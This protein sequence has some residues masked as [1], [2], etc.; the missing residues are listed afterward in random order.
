[1]TNRTRKKA[2]WIGSESTFGTAPSGSSFLYVPAVQIGEL[3]DTLQ[4][5][6]TDYFTNRSFG[7]APVVGPDGWS[8]D[9]DVPVC[10][11]ELGKAGGQSPS[12]D[13][14]LDLIC[15]SIFGTQY[16][17]DGLAVAST[18]SSTIT[19]D[20]G[21]HTQQDLLPTYDAGITVDGGNR[22]QWAFATS[23]S[24]ITPNWVTN[25]SSSAVVYAA[26]SYRFDDDGGNTFALQL[27]QDAIDYKLEGGRFSKAV[28][29]GEMG[30]INLLRLTAIGDRKSVATISSLPG[31]IT[32]W[33]RVTQTLLSPVFFNGTKYP[34]KRFEID[35]G[36][37]VN[38]QQ[39]TEALNGRASIDVI[40]MAP[41]IKIQPL[42][43]SAIQD[44]KRTPT[45]GRTFVQFGSGA[46]DGGG[47][48][49]TCCFYAEEGCVMSADP[50]DDG[51]RLR[52]DVTIH[53]T[54]PINNY[55]GNIG[56]YPVQFARA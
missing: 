37:T 12:A 24:A 44:L 16:S 39:S 30:Q 38:D 23:S 20:S 46:L 43:T 10:G 11:L 42:F 14:F 41:T 13:D 32:I 54:D 47:V 7:T 17:R 33:P 8:L 36:L 15:S 22:T 45:R 21:S 19:Y 9:I 40:R 31:P 35:L 5:L 28:F 2:L 26:K 29:I 1:M 53:C 49:N 52:N 3:K 48:L 51:G 50:V 55:S 27:Q 4:L 34:T 25:P 18:T 56:S 6:K